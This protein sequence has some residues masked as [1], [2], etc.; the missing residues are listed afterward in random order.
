[1]L[2]FLKKTAETPVLKALDRFYVAGGVVSAIGWVGSN[3]APR[4]LY[5]GKELPI[6]MCE[7][8]QRPDVAAVHG[9]S[10][11][12]SGFR[13]CAF[14]PDGAD[15]SRLSVR[16]SDG[17]E[18]ARSAAQPGTLYAILDRFKA[19]VAQRPD[20]H[21]IEIGSRA[22]SGNTYR[23]MFEGLK[24][25]TGI[26]VA[27]GP[28]VDVVA[29]AHRLSSHFDARFDFAFSISV[30]EHLVMPWVA[31]FELN[32][33]MKP[34]GIGYIQSHQAWPLHEVP[35]DFFRFSEHS[36]N[37]LFNHFTGFEVVEAGFEY[38]AMLSSHV[39]DGRIFEG[40]DQAQCHLLSGCMIRKIGNPTVDWS[41]DASQVINL[42]YSY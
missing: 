18:I 39:I 30:F 21:M 25:Y 37:G 34:G 42:K 24:N 27:A 6:Q 35:W 14:I 13:T 31:A 1:M 29:D 5:D 28:N 7:R 33:V 10:F 19:Q 36:W 17:T 2:G 22:R 38:P 4:I 12:R 23:Q 20:G 40:L 3:E 11:A 41:A 9:D 8:G 16:F 32:K 26:D 15:H